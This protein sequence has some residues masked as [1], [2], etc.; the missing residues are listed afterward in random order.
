MVACCPVSKGFSQQALKSVL[1]LRSA[2]VICQSYCL[3]AFSLTTATRTNG[4]CRMT[5]CSVGPGTGVEVKA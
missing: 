1:C 4:V 3:K 5:A 2:G